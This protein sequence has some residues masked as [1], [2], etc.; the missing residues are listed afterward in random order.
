M[1]RKWN[2]MTIQEKIDRFNVLQKKS[3]LEEKEKQEIN[4]LAS[5]FLAITKQRFATA[6]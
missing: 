6:S 1:E 4:H 5:E 3:N 2:G